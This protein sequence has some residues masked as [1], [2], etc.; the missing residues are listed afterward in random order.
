[1]E[2]TKANTFDS[3]MN[4]IASTYQ[5]LKD[6]I[7]EKYASSSKVKEYY[8]AEDG[9]TQ[10]LTKEKDSLNQFWLNLGISS[11]ARNTLN[12]IWDCYANLKDKN[13]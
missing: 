7:D 12:R 3:Y 4:K 13:G 9:T 11:S 1:M 8:T 6:R 5:L 10:E 2:K